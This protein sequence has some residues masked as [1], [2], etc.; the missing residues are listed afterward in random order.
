MKDTFLL[1]GTVCRIGL[2]MNVLVLARL[3]TDNFGAQK[4]NMH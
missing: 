2:K 1:C 3:W 4:G